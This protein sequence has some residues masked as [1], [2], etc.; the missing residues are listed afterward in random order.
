MRK[1]HPEAIQIKKDIRSGLEHF[2]Y[3]GQGESKD[4]DIDTKLA[5]R[6]GERVDV[7]FHGF[8]FLFLVRPNLHPPASQFSVRCFCAC[9]GWM[10]MSDESGEG[11]IDNAGY[12]LFVCPSLN[13]A[14]MPSCVDR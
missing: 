5:S 11:R 6:F 7:D 13:W 9:V 2:C 4:T 1:C 10:P 8:F 12:K 3:D 14:S